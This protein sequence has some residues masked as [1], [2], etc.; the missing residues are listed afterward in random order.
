MLFLYNIAAFTV[1]YMDSTAVHGELVWGIAEEFAG[2]YVS[3]PFD[4]GKIPHFF[5]LPILDKNAGSGVLQTEVDVQTES[6]DVLL[7][8][9]NS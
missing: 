4:D 9:A 1:I 7:S 5:L 3:L 8:F 6:L 2:D